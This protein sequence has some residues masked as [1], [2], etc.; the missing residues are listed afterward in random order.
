MTDDWQDIS[1]PA[2][3]GGDDWQNVGGAG[4]WQPVAAPKPPDAHQDALNGAMQ[5]AST[6]PLAAV[7]D[8]GSSVARQIPYMHDVASGVDAAF[9]LAPGDTF[10]ERFDKAEQ[11]QQVAA[12]ASKKVNPGA[13]RLGD[14]SAYLLQAGL[15]TP[16]L[17]GLSR[18]QRIAAASGVGAG[19]GAASGSDNVDAFASDADAAKQR[20]HGAEIGAATGAVM[21]PVLS[22]VAPAMAKAAY[23]YL[24]PSGRAAAAAAQ[25]ALPTMDQLRNVAGRTFDA[26]DEAGGAL[27][28][29]QHD[30]VIDAI[31]SQ[32]KRSPEAEAYL[33]ESPLSGMAE[34]AEKLRGKPMSFQGATEIDKE[35]TGMIRKETG[36]DGFVTPLGQK[37]VAV[38][39]VLRDA[40]EAPNAGSGFELQ[41]QAKALW[42]Q[43]ARMRDIQNIIDRSSRMSNPAT[44]LQVGFRQLLDNGRRMRGFDDGDRKIIQR[45]ADNPSAA[46][47][48][49]RSAGS[50]L[51]NIASLGH[52]PVSGIATN[53]GTTA[54]RGISKKLAFRPAEQLLDRLATRNELPVLTKP[55]QAAGGRVK[56]HSGKVVKKPVS[57]PAI[58]AMRKRP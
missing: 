50:R 8:Y 47:E 49:M 51:L 9:G 13:T 20:L 48:L 28:P 31:A 15:P 6:D 32:A 26:A 55:Y 4:D 45:I 53:L 46:M 57:Y 39:D 44:S 25:N 1:S 33:G 23:R 11:N 5:R 40:M 10:K 56:T 19:Y 18:A 52:G 58:E 21:G 22:E 54:A 43:Q 29:A 37:Y 42:A 2:P 7:V 36:T 14:T 27:T 34:N 24:T 17:Q 30:S 16:E 35:L 12:E 3:A 41:N 38:Q